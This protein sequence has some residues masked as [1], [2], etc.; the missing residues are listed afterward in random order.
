MLKG[1]IPFDY[2]EQH[3]ELFSEEAMRKMM[4]KAELRRA[5]AAEADASNAGTMILNKG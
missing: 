4:E 3:P 5:A 1:G 2:R